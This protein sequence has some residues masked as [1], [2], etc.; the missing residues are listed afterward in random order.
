MQNAECRVKSYSVGTGVLDG[1]KTDGF[2]VLKIGRSEKITRRNVLL[3]FFN[4]PSRTP[5][6]TKDV[7]FHL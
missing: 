4:G 7:F 3:T 2:L 1:P 5:V 6:P